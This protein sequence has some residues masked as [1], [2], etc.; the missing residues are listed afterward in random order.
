MSVPSLLLAAKSS[1][2]LRA[3]LAVS[4]SGPTIGARAAVF[5]WFCASVLC[6]CSRAAIMP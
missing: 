6:H 2:A 5:A 1:A 3:A 4:A